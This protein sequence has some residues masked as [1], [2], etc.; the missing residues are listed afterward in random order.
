MPEVK[1]KQPHTHQG[2]RVAAGE[3]ITVT[4]AEEVWLREHEIIGVAPVVNDLQS[5]RGRNK[6]QEPEDNGTV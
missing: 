4:E 5:N 2:K 3:T 6:Q 1:L